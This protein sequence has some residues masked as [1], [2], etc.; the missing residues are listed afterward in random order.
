M[1][2]HVLVTGSLFRAP[3]QRT[4]SSGR[5]YVKATL[6][7]SAADNTTSEF[8]DLLVFSETAGVELLRLG[9]NERLAVQGSLKTELYQ[10]EGKPAKIQ[11]TIFVDHVL[12]LRAAPREKKPKASGQT[13]PA[14]PP[15]ERVNIIPAV[16]SDLP[17]DDIPF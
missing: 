17:N 11:R 12:A 6:R 9:E 2:A 1:T 5:K 4:S 10:P 15:L 13:T 16:S 7:A 8:W 14:R 3:E